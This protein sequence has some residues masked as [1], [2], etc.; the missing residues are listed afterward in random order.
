MNI[1]GS[2]LFLAKCFSASTNKKTINFLLVLLFLLDPLLSNGQ[3]EANFSTPDTVGCGSLIANFSNESQGNN[4][5]YLWDFGNGTTSTQANPQVVYTNTGSYTVSLI[6]WNGSNTDTLIKTNY[7]HVF[8]SPEAQFKTN[9][10]TRGCA[11]LTIQLLNT[12]DTTSQLTTTLWDFGDGNSSE[13][14]QP[15]YTYNKPGV[16]TVSLYIKDTHQCKSS[17]SRT[18]YIEVLPA[19]EARFTSSKHLT[20]TDTLTVQFNNQS[21][22]TPPLTYSW[23]FGTG[24]T[25]DQ[26]APE[27]FYPEYGKYSVHLTVTDEFGCSDSI[28]KIDYV[29]LQDLEANFSL[30]KEVYCPYEQLEIN[31]TT[32]GATSHFWDFND[33]TTSTRKTPDK[34]Y[35]DTG[36]FT[37]T[38][39]AGFK[40]TCFDT[41][42]KPVNI[43]PIVANF[44]SDTNY[45]CELPTKVNYT[46]NS[47]NAVAYH[48]KFGDG[49]VSQQKNPSVTYTMTTELE[50]S[51]VAH[52]TDT[53]I[54][55]SSVGCSD[56]AILKNN[57]YINVPNVYFTPN[58]SNT[59]SNLIK[60][61]IPVDIDFSDKSYTNN[62]NDSLIS[63][64]WSFD[65]GTHST[66]QN[67]SHRYSN[68][69]VY[70][71]TLEVTNQT[72]C[73]NTH[74]ATIQAGTIQNAAFSYNGPSVICGSKIVTFKDE[75]T[76]STLID[77]WRW[78]FS[79]GSSSEGR[80]PEIQFSDTGYINASLTV[81]YNG[82]MGTTETKDSIVFVKGPAG[83]FLSEF[84]CDAPFQYQFTNHVKGLDEWYWD[85]G[86]ATTD[87]T[88]S[89][90]AGH[91]YENAGNY[92]V[93]LSSNNA[94]T[95]CELEVKKIVRPR[96]IVAD[97]AISPEFNCKNDTIILDP[98]LSQ[99]AGY[100]SHENQLALYLWTFKD[101]NITM[102]STKP[103][104]HS[105]SRPGDYEVE[106]L[107][108]D[109]NGCT[110]KITK[111]IPVNRVKADYS[112]DNF[113]GCAPLAVQ[114][115]NLSTAD[116]SISSYLWFSGNETIST[117]S[118]PEILFNQQQKINV[119]LII[120]DAIGCQ[121]TLIKEQT[122]T[123]L[124]PYTNFKASTPF[125]CK[126][127]SVFFAADTLES[128]NSYIWEF[129]D[130]ETANSQYATHVFNDTGY[131]NPTL[132]ITDTLGCDT[133][134]T[135]NKYVYTQP[136][137]HASFMANNTFSS[138]YP[139]IVKLQDTTT[140]PP[141][142]QWN[143]NFGD[144]TT[145]DGSKNIYHTYNKSGTFDV[146][147]KVKTAIG[148][149]GST[150]Y[151]NFI[152]IGGPY[153]EIVAPDSFC[154][155]LPSHISF[156]SPNN[157]LSFSWNT[158]DG[159]QYND[160]MFQKVWETP[161]MK[162]IY[163]SLKSDTLGTCDKLLSDSVIIPV[164][165]AGFSTDPSQG[166][167]PLS[168][169][170]THESKGA[171]SYQYALN[172]VLSAAPNFS[173]NFT[174]AGEKQVKQLVKNNIGCK[175]S[176][177]KTITVFP[178]PTTN[179]NNDTL[180]C[181]YDYIQ[182]Q[183]HNGINYQW[184][185]SNQPIG[186][187]TSTLFVSPDTTTQY[188]VIVTDKNN[189]INN[190]SAIVQVQPQP[191]VSIASKDSA[192]L[193]IGESIELDATTQHTHE[194][195][196]T[197]EE[198][199]LCTDCT[200]TSAIPE[201]SGFIYIT[202]SDAHSCFEVTDSVFVFV[203]AKYS[204]DLPDAFTPNNDGINDVINVKGWGIKEL[205]TFKVFNSAGKM[206]FETDRIDEG[207]NGA[208]EN[209][210]QPA[211]VYFY[212]VEIVSY[213][214]KLRAKEGHFYMN[215]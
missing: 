79:D 99:D 3:V 28:I 188:K 15:E 131:F 158:S 155:N 177:V 153:A 167:V 119:G 166:C 98:S 70:R 157:I 37:I 43:D 44:V 42:T 133:S 97:F 148:C 46:S 123:I 210:K 139:S 170:F 120:T 7:I 36:R 175:D 75:S 47:K 92:E 144:G 191:M 117:D 22:G 181:Q 77:Q 31:N 187:T 128:I 122:L 90:T 142:E 197:P 17:F 184:Y 151:N 10:P 96:E 53:L 108:R 104:K 116:T 48:W 84:N 192:Q 206:V 106:L 196:W 102:A 80:I 150:T 87:S 134:I 127:D 202:G 111:T 179:L 145:L 114:F 93:V 32:D 183:A 109:I 105:F 34:I 137:P 164:L 5:N 201:Q 82:C 35:S 73:V 200:K 140:Y 39:V 126:G 169:N 173:H 81:F 69:G 214:N 185:A 146:T 162:K 45:L 193:I 29:E 132:T 18:A 58:D 94:S 64:Y 115:N 156:Q 163:L 165:D 129:G 14:T 16:Y 8:P 161:G 203:D 124:K 56:T 152:S 13:A 95:N 68:T 110:N 6:V 135:K 178:L 209:G 11:P 91:T 215:Y 25:S 205:L 20:C 130:G 71:V 67:I 89:I 30:N 23:G 136:L 212:R 182:L 2:I 147:L 41:L 51:P 52:Y 65:D 103:I 160:T 194:V 4:L 207:W 154:V 198:I 24:A 180:I 54:V 66:Q 88:Q 171:T 9:S 118:S 33:Q 26:M 125:H 208:S 83:T 60:G 61:C 63:R 168:V 143:W 176:L 186:S 141:I 76:D 213:D 12:S 190:D 40:N 78:D 112:I 138:C 172:Q 57:I 85:F 74:V 86:D 19:P 72:G 113:E 211:G 195:Y 21:S 121:D 55:V 149:S 38:Y 100:F 59:Y 62:P 159:E 1:S 189:C 199:V 174:N 50:S 101:S 49:S 27:Y 204:I 107:V